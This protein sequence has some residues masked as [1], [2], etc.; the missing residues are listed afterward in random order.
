MSHV[1]AEIEG[2]SFETVNVEA[3]HQ[4]LKDN[5]MSLEIVNVE[6]THPRLFF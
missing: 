3:T 6:A 4:P 5:G 1:K 2:L